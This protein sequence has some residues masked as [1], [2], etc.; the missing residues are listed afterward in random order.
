MKIKTQNTN[1]ETATQIRCVAEA[2]LNHPDYTSMMVAKLTG[3]SDQMVIVVRGIV[4]GWHEAMFGDL[5]KCQSKI[6]GEVEGLLEIKQRVMD[7]LPIQQ[8]LE[9]KAAEARFMAD[10]VLD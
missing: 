4:A 10:L 7:M 2:L 9:A 3:A 6:L 5:V 1:P 8:Q